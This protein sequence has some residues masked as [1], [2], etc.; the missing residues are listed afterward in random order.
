MTYT[1]NAV[2]IGAIIGIGRYVVEQIFVPIPPDMFPIPPGAVIRFPVSIEYP[3]MTIAVALVIGLV[4]D[5]V[6][7]IRRRLSARRAA[8]GRAFRV[9]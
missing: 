7:F 8:A 4:A 3:M 9:R 6:A 1:R 5:G 2:F